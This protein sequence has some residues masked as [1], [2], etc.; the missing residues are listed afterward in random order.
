MG[1]TTSPRRLGFSAR[2]RQQA[3][4]TARLARSSCASAGLHLHGMDGIWL[5]QRK[6]PSGDKN[7]G[8]GEISCSVIFCSAL[9]CS[10]LRICYCCA[11]AA[12]LL[13]VSVADCV[14]LVCV[15]VCY[16]IPC[17]KCLAV[18]VSHQKYFD[19]HFWTLCL[20][21][22]HQALIT[23]VALRRRLCLLSYS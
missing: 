2:R 15:F 8:K 22:A 4:R 6:T 9:L 10:A 11:T 16:I 13:K 19:F 1:A 23:V 5:G 7:A 3:T 21:Q 18:R 17:Q 14:A 12:A 20:L